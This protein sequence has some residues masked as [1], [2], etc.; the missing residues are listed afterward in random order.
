MSAMPLWTGEAVAGATGGE[1][2]TAWQACGV[3]IDSRTVR[4]GELF[5]PI[6]G[7]NFDGH[8][9]IADALAKGAVAA[10]AHR[11]PRA[12]AD[13][14]R[15]M[16]VADTLAALR[17][18]LDRRLRYPKAV[19][20]QLGVRLLGVVPEVKSLRSLGKLAKRQAEARA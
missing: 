5:V 20:R 17:Q 10:L 16:M 6:A 4:P 18:L 1:G 3:S 15:V 19:E 7:P 13:D 14:R 8:D 9:F 12:P 2:P 11:L